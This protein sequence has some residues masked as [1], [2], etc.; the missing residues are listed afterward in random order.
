[1]SIRVST[2]ANHRNMD[3]RA[4]FVLRAAQRQAGRADREWRRRRRGTGTV[5]A[6]LR[7]STKRQDA[8]VVELWGELLRR[9][10]LSAPSDLA[11]L[12][13]GQ[14]GAVGAREVELYLVDYELTE[15]IPLPVAAADRRESLSVAGTVAG[16]AFSAT[17]IL[18]SPRRDGGHRRFWFPLLD[19]T[20]RLGVMGMSFDAG[21]V[22]DDTIAVCERYAHLAAL[23]IVSKGA[24]SDTFEIVRRRRP[25]TIASELLWELVPPLVFATDRLMVGAMLEPCYD[26]GGDAFDYAIN[27]GVLHLA[28]FDAMGHGLPAAAVSAFA[29]SAYRHS[30]RQGRDLLEA[31]QAIDGAIADQFPD[32]RYVTAV[33]AQLDLQT[34]RL[35][36]VSAG[37][38]PPLVI[39]NGRRARTLS[40]RPATPLGVALGQAPQVV[41]ESLEPGDMLLLYTDGLTEARGVD[42]ERFA[43]GGLTAFIERE[44]ATGQTAAEVL[45]RLRHAVVAQQDG[46]LDDDA[47]AVLVEWDRRGEIASLPPTVIDR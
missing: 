39:R 40:A 33:L 26:N 43:I 11:A 9:T 5:V 38:P 42:G 25:M 13:A 17:T 2:I 36:W 35:A 29:I 7:D 16:R 19:G 24:Y 46:G 28:V 27:D 31:Y 10:H 15:L 20:E 32:E 12:I 14:A 44:A 41:Q 30:R 47:T 22:D 1:M 34:G 6:D 21:E 23:L 45:R 18:E 37:H 3:S 8:R 4:S